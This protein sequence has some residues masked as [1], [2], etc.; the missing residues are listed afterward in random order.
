MCS[1]GKSIP[2]NWLAWL[3]RGMLVVNKLSDTSS[4]AVDSPSTDQLSTR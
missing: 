3:D 4:L 1:C 2:A